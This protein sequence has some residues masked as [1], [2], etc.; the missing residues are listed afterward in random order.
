MQAKPKTYKDFKNSK[1]K[2]E[3]IYKIYRN[4]LIKIIGIDV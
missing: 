4:Y 1:R 3:F 2:L